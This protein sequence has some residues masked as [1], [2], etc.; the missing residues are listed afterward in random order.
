MKYIRSIRGIAAS[1][2]SKQFCQWDRQQ[3][4]LANRRQLL[5]H[6]LT[7]ALLG[8]VPAHA[9]YMRKRT[10]SRIDV[11]RSCF[12]LLSRFIRCW[13]ASSAAGRLHL[14]VK[15]RYVLCQRLLYPLCPPRLGLPYACFDAHYSPSIPLPVLF[16][17]PPP[18]LPL[19]SLPS[20]QVELLQAKC[21]R[22]EAAVKA[23]FL[24]QM[25][26]RGCAWLAMEQEDIEK[27]KEQAGEGGDS[28]GKGGGG[29][30]G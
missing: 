15:Q 19:P 8:D 4:R 9:S 10:C 27:C 30:R 22:H 17:L 12:T 25:N 20:P 6:S 16:P 3:I 5:H 26:A 7:P 28:Q 23:R 24:K 29:E 1:A 18:P 14:L 11:R 2:C 13:A 21:R